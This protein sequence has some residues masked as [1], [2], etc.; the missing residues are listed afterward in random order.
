MHP[1]VNYYKCT[2]CPQLVTESV[3]VISNDL[4]HDYH[5]VHE[6][7]KA[8]VS[9]LQSKL[10]PINVIYHFSDCCANQYRS[11]GPF[12]DISYAIKDCNVPIQHNFSGEHNG[13]DAVQSNKKAVINM[14]C[15]CFIFCFCF[16]KMVLQSLISW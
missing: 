10:A 5:A 14:C 9:H 16:C 11:Q 4:M 1:F 13:K 2:N 12:S 7:Q 6:F 15:C 8:V 3:V